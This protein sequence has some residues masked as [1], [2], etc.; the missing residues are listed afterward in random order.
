MRLRPEEFTRAP[1]VAPT[2]PSTEYGMAPSGVVPETWSRSGGLA[3]RSEGF[4]GACFYLPAMNANAQP[5][6]M[7]LPGF[8]YSL[9]AENML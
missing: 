3:G 6:G 4:F 2:I 1:L 8:L 7:V 9:V 5:G